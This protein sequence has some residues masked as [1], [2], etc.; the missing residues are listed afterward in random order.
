MNLTATQKQ[1]FASNARQWGSLAVSILGVLSVKGAIPG[2][3][4]A[5]QTLMV[6]LFPAIQ[7]LEHSNLS[8]GGPPA[9]APP[10]PAQPTPQI[11]HTV[12]AGTPIAPVTAMPV[13]PAS[14]GTGSPPSPIQPA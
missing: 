14:A 11:S 13:P 8:P 4:A 10:P 2:L 1:Q 9:S 7:L 6:S 5:I 3:P 12:T